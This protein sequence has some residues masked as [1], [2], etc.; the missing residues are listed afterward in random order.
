MISVCMATYNG[1]PYLRS[2]VDSILSQLGPGDELVV[3]DDN[4]SDNTIEILESYRDP[5]IRIFKFKQEKEG[6]QP[7]QLVTSNFENALKHAKGD[8]IYMADQDD[9]WATDKVTEC[10]KYLKDFDY[11]VTDC[12]VT[13]ADLNVKSTTRF[14]GSVTRNRWKALLKPTPWQ[15]SCAAFRRKVLDRALPFPTGLQSHDRW[16][17][18]IGSLIYR[19]KIIDKP[20]IYYRRH[21]HNTSTAT[22][23][24]SSSTLAKINTRLHYVK[25]LL[26]RKFR[27]N[28]HKH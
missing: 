26:K 13:D 25:H 28:S 6:L 1:A 7:V 15:G 17:G 24:G 10:Q 23:G 3:S 16:I 12:Y 5:R 20:L 27:I 14:D 4:S 8:Y 18:F 11:V 9:V 21:G 2:Q 22:E 19:A